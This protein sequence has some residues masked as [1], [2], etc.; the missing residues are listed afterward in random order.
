MKSLGE[1]LRLESNMRTPPGEGTAMLGLYR[2]I[3]LGLIAAAIGSALSVPV[4]RA[5]TDDIGHMRLIDRLDRPQDGYCLD[6]L[7]TGNNLQLQ[8][9]VF[10][11]N[12]KP[13]L[14]P[15]S[16][17]TMSTAGEIR[18]VAVELCVTAFGVNGRALPTAPIILR[19]C[20]HRAPFFDSTPLQRFEWTPDNQLRLKQTMLCLSVGEQSDTTYSP[21]DRWRMLTV[22]KC[23][24]IP[25]A[26]AAWEFVRL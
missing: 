3:V 20:G 23:S 12:C 15:D 7:G 14:T 6:V 4:A 24:S 16:A 21:A 22:E 10:A 17:V 9:P 26:R 13:G 19:P 5:E 25:T 8:L 2:T 18:F 11:H 1:A